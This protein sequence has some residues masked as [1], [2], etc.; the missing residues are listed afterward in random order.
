MAVQ[1]VLDR[2]ATILEA[3]I[4]GLAVGGVYAGRP[5]DI[6]PA[7]FPAV[8]IL[9]GPSQPYDY[10]NTGMA[11][12]VVITRQYRMLFLGKYWVAD[13]ELDA[14]QVCR[15][16]FDR[17]RERFTGCPTLEHPKGLNPVRFIQNARLSG[18]SGVVTLVLA[19]VAY[20]GIEFTIDIEE[21]YTIRFA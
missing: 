16:F 9:T 12:T 4:E 7:Q 5:D 20:S 6:P 18:D 13:G 15:P 19:G 11:K 10:E 2:L 17:F 3:D 21:Y 8:V 1:D 14:E